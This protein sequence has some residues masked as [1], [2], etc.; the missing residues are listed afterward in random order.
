[1][2]EPKWVTI[3]GRHVP[4][5]EDNLIEP[6]SDKAFSTW[7]EGEQWLQDKLGYTEDE[8]R[9]LSYV[10]ESWSNYNS[11]EIHNM[12]DEDSVIGTGKQQSEILDKYLNDSRLAK[13]KGTLYRGLS[14]KKMSWNEQDIQN[15]EKQLDSGVW[16]EP[17]ITAFSSDAKI[18]TGYTGL[19]IS[20]SGIGVVI[21]MHG[22]KHAVPIGHLSIGGGEKE[23]L[24]PS[25]IRDKGLKIVSWTKEP[26]AIWQRGKNVGKPLGWLYRVIVEDR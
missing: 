17:G 2:A 19:T 16:K 22:N 1:M 20:S 3:N 18:A 21:E 24:Y 25:S 8:A 6:P 15:L 9:H 26:T 10:M 4:I 7:Q 14:Y 5:Y 23:S 13:T 11:S 12:S